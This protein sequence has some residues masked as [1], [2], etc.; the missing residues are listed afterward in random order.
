MDANIS[1]R[2]YNEL[3]PWAIKPDGSLRWQMT[4]GSLTCTSDRLLPS[5]PGWRPGV[6]RYNY[7]WTWA[8]RQQREMWPSVAE[9]I[10]T[11]AV[12]ASD[13]KKTD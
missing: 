11:A 6:P 9:L 3:W 12:I 10:T 5:E 4:G 2:L 7:D 8:V 13:R 1:I